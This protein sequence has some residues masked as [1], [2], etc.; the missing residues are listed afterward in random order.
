MFMHLKLFS[1]KNEVTTLKDEDIQICKFR[2]CLQGIRENVDTLVKN[3]DGQDRRKINNYKKKLLA[4]FAE[5]YRKQLLYEVATE[6][7]NRI[8]NLICTKKCIHH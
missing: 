3:M 6:D 4:A 1:K 8:K 2:R 7:I 5:M